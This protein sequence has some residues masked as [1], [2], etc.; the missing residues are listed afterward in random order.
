MRFGKWGGRPHWEMDLRYLGADQFGDWLGSPAGMPMRR[1]GW[2]TRTDAE[3]A[4]LVP[5]QGDFVASFNGRGVPTAI[6]VDVTDTPHW[7]GETVR[8]VDLDLPAWRRG[9]DV[10]KAWDGTLLV[11]DEDWAHARQ[12]GEF[13]EHQVQYGYPPEVVDAAQRS[14][15]DLVTAIAG[16]QEPW[17]S[18]GHAW[19]AQA[20]DLP[21]APLP[22]WADRA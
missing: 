9:P 16:D 1:P 20:A 8:A 19:C 10:V 7:D 13:A 2:T 11:D 14:C 3:C 6:Y 4:F 5:M 21:L 17:A 15:D 12:G 18:V 22:D